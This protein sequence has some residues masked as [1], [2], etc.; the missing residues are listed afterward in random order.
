M[1]GADRLAHAR[2]QRADRIRIGEADRIGKRDLVDA[3]R[4]DPLGELHHAIM[5]HVAFQRAAE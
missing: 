3:D 2:K 5:R 4:R 1:S